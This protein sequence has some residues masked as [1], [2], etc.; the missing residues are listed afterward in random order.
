MNALITGN[1]SSGKLTY[2]LARI[3]LIAGIVACVGSGFAQTLSIQSGSAI[4]VTQADSIVQ[5]AAESQGLTQ[6]EPTDLPIIGGT[7]WW[8]MPGGTAVPAPCAPLDLS[9]PIYQVADGQFLVDETGGQEAA[10]TPQFGL[11]AQTTSSTFASPLATQ[12]DAVV[13][14]ITQIQTKAANQQARATMQAMG[15]D[16]PSPGGDGS[17]DGGDGYSPMFSSSYSINT[18]GLWLEITNV[19]NGW[20]YLNLH[21]GTNQVYAL[22]SATNLL[23]GWQVEREVWPTNGTVIPTVTPFLVQNLNRQNLFLRAEDW[24]GITENGNTT[25]DWW[26][27]LY[28]GTTALSDTNLDSQGYTL[29]ND[30]QNG[31]DPNFIQFSLSVTNQYINNMSAPVKLNVTKG[32][33]SYFAVL[34]DDTNFADAV[35]NTYTSSNITVYLGLT[36]GWHDVWVGLRGLPSNAMQTWQWKHLNLTLPPV[37]VITNPVTGVV[38]EPMIQIY[39]YCQDSLASISYD[40]SNALGVVTNQPSEITDQ[41]YDTNACA[42]TTN[43]FECL[44]VPLTNGLNTITI[45][46]TDLA[47]D[48]TTTNFYFTLDYSSKTNPPTV[49]VTWPQNGT[50]ISGNYFTCRGVINDPT[51]TVTALVV[52]TNSDTNT[53]SNGVYTNTYMASVERNGNFWLENLPLNAGTNTFTIRVKDAAGNTS[54][55]NVN[56]VKSSFTLTVNPVTPD[57]Q[58]WQ[59]TVNL[60]GTISDATYAVWVNGVKGHNNGNGTWSASNVPTSS[61]GT[62]SFTVTAY[63]PNEQQPDGSYGN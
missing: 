54:V 37:L 23:T 16:V 52:F 42:F 57:S 12:A 30:Y 3:V 46:A 20:S 7:F 56:V 27:W 19:S 4:R 63:A 9:A 49:Q 14:L 28:F 26:F 58:L 50:Q 41:Y 61:G 51:A 55:T 36:Q 21:N 31:I 8:V 1:G 39:G 10:N 59:P 18:N 43:Y 38:D 53:F 44:D 48:T 60:T 62:A 11:Q 35:W 45:H 32:V 33:P 13:N 40:I 29:L 15:M 25:P 47:G 5:I 6:I 17:G 2:I 22:W 24:T 34:V